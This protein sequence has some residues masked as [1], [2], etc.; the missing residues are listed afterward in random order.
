MSDCGAEREQ[1]E[2]IADGA[3]EDAC[4][5]REAHLMAVKRESQARKVHAQDCEHVEQDVG[6]I[7]GD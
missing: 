5:T 2:G 7:G 3:C 4:G 1:A 6:A